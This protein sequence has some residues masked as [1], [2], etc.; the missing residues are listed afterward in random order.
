M[1]IDWV[2]FNKRNVFLG[3]VSSQCWNRLVWAAAILD[4]RTVSKSSLKQLVHEANALTAV[5]I[6]MVSQW[7]IT[8]PCTKSPEHC[9]SSVA[10]GTADGKASMKMQQH[11]TRNVRNR[12][13]SARTVA[14]IAL[15]S[16]KTWPH[17]LLY[18]PRESC[19]VQN[20]KSQWCGN[21]CRTTR[22]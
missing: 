22:Q 7:K 16:E 6:S 3:T 17:T 4:A 13:S 1:Q 5:F 10:M 2:Q 19:H 12:R 8:S 21:H 18:V 9:L 11:I 14:V 15:K 20:A